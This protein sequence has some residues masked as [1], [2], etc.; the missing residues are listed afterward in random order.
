M[1]TES[2]KGTMEVGRSDAVGEGTMV[3]SR[4]DEN[5]KMIFWLVEAVLSKT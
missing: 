3:G 2:Y 5:Y 1:Q 4:G